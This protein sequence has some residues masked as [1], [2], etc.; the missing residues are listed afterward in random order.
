[1]APYFLSKTLSFSLCP[2]RSGDLDSLPD[3]VTVV[4]LFDKSGI[5][6]SFGIAIMSALVKVGGFA[7]IYCPA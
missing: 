6:F 5:I 1:M 7:L 2:Y 4:P 3:L